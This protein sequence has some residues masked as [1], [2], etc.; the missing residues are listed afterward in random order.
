MAALARCI[1]GIE[2]NVV[3]AEQCAVPLLDERQTRHQHEKATPQAGLLSFDQ[4]RSGKEG[5]ARAGCRHECRDLFHRQ[6]FDDDGQCV[7]LPCAERHT[8]IAGVMVA[9]LEIAGR[10]PRFE[11][12]L[13]SWAAVARRAHVCNVERFEC[14]RVAAALADFAA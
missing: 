3:I 12:F 13:D 1:R 8:R 11:V 5:F 14:D 7:L 4:G 9:V 10:A 6:C 2:R